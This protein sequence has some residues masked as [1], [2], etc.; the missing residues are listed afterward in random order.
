M[1]KV[2]V[3]RLSGCPQCKAL[4]HTLD[5]LNVKY[6]SIDVGGYSKIADDVERLIKVEI[7]PIVIIEQ[8]PITTYFFR[9]DDSYEL[10]VRIVNEQTIKIG[11]ATTDAMVH[12]IQTTLNLK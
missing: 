5:A 11:C 4:I 2:R 1:N 8:S 9:A 12:L 3:L 10:G 6:E 7:Y